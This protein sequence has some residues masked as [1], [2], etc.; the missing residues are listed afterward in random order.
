MRRLLL[1][2]MAMAADVGLTDECAVA[3]C[4][5]WFGRLKEMLRDRLISC[6]WR[7]ELKE[8]CKGGSQCWQRRDLVSYAH[9]SGVFYSC[10]LQR[11]SAARDSRTSRSTSSSRRSLLADDVS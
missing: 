7:D 11:S 4:A 1:C 2:V 10:Y 3:T 9:A 6:G 5:L 8:Y